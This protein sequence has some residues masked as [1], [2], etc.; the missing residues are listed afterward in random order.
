M[1]G[2]YNNYA[3]NVCT[4]KQYGDH[5]L[6]VTELAT[7]RI[8]GLELENPKEKNYAPKNT[9]NDDKL[10][11]NLSRA[12]STIRELI[13]CNSWDYFCTLTLCKE[14][15]NRYDLNTFQH[16]LS[17]FLHNYN[18]RC[19]EN[20]KVRY[21]L[22][23]EM[24]KDGAWHMHGFLTGIRPSDIYLNDKGYLGWRSYE[25]RFGFINFSKIIDSDKTA[26]YATKYITKDSAKNVSALGA[27]LY[28]AS[29][30]LKRSVELHRGRIQLH[31]CDWDYIH[32]DGF[33]RTKTF[34]MRYSDY[35]SCIEVLE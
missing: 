26:S 8:P 10:D 27:H 21:L 30:G 32:P 12:R 13:L 35:D 18:R 20:E 22:I 1:F 14:K 29:K 19:T 11:C 34:D 5:I 6:K 7:M 2:C 4:V 25:N 17:A 9:V 33:C 31:N 24:H 23:P 28:Y 3:S 16:E 15:Y